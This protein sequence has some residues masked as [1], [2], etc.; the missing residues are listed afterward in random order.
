MTHHDQTTA[1]DEIMELLA[2]HGFDGMA[3]AIGVLLNEVMK[4]ERTARPRGRPLPAV[5]GTARATPTASSPRP[6]TPGSG[7][8]TVAGA[9]DPGR[10]VLPLGPG[11]GRPQRAGLE[12][13]RRRD[14]RPGR[15]DPQGR[16]HHREA[17]R[18]G[19]HQLAGQPGRRGP[20][21]GAGEVAGPPA[22]RDAVPDPRRPL[23]EGPPRR[24]GRLV[25]RAGG[26][27]H[28]HRRAGG[29]SSGSA[30]RCRRPR[31]TGGTSWPRCRPGACTASGWSPATPTPG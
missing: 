26:H 18:A 4:L 27:R 28:R 9:P 25:C 1:L 12:A 13:G 19:G 2:E 23:R 10:R 29:R 8:S 7:P 24:L 15:L 16:R 31:S 21:R 17:L 5:R 22:R 3:Q 11:E 20:R 14:V 6:C 30:S